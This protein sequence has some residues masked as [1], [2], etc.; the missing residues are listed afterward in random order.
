[1][2]LAEVTIRNGFT[3]MLRA[4]E[5]AAY[6]HRFQMRKCVP[7]IPYINHPIEVANI[8]ASAGVVDIDTLVA[9][10]LHD[11]VEDTAA[12][13]V[14]IKEHFGSDVAI[15]VGWVTDDKSLPKAER[16]RLQVAHAADPSMP[17][18]AKL[19]KLADKISN[20]RS[21]ASGAPAGWSQAEICGYF[22]WAKCVFVAGLE[23]L[24]PAL[25]AEFKG[26]FGV[27]GTPTY[28][29]T[30]AKNVGAYYAMFEKSK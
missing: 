11:T 8:L 13:L 21:F 25:D 23:G 9:A 12:T 18:A 5:Y 15:Y 6:C 7:A 3:K 19:V 4:T 14:N 24:N 10:L 2:S 22:V 1:M 16:K 26:T 28:A 30:D 27:H 20:L 29:E 17:V